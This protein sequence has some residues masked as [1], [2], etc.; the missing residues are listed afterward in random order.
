MTSG[1]GFDS[2]RMRRL[3]SD[4]DRMCSLVANCDLIR[5]ENAPV[6]P[7]EQ[8]ALVYTCRGIADIDERDQPI[9]S[10]LH[11]VIIRLPRDYPL[12]KPN[13]H[14][15]TP[16]FHPNIIGDVCIDWAAAMSLD[17][18]CVTIGHLIQYRIYNLYSPLNGRAAS[19]AKAH[20]HLL[21]VDTR[22][23]KLGLAGVE[24]TEKASIKI[25]IRS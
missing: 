6:L 2:P 13:T 1:A 8:Y 9:F 16:I 20:A 12:Q 10:E 5:I 21:P 25:R 3:R 15:S 22:P 14:V 17:E 7:A 24:K 23:M 11:R 19:W 4:Y 18:Y